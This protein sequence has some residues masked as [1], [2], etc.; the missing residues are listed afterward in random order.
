METSPSAQS[1]D[2]GQEIQV[3]LDQT[4]ATKAVTRTKRGSIL[5]K[6]GTK[7]DDKDRWAE[8][9][10]AVKARL[11]RQARS[12]DQKM[13]EQQAEHQRQIAALRSEFQGVNVNRGQTGDQLD[14]AHETTMAA[15]QK[16]LEE[17]LETGNAV[18]AAKIQRDMAS[19]EGK[20]WAAKTAKQTGGSSEN[21][22]RTE[23]AATTT[24]QPN[25]KANGPAPTKAGI[26]WAKA[27]TDWWDD[28]TDDV[29]VAA[30]SMANGLYAIAIRDGDD[31]ADP[32]LYE[33]IGTQVAKRFP[34]LGVK[35]KLNGRKGDDDDDDEGAST[36][37]GD[38][39]RGRAPV[40]PVDRTG[41][42]G[43][44]QANQ[45]RNVRTLDKTDQRTMRAMGLNPDDNKHV[46]EFL[47]QK[48]EY[49]AAQ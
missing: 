2:D 41:D 46:L 32:A 37:L 31:T 13:A 42:R 45:H 7:E 43:S 5:A 47:S 24:T 35:V 3:D 30:R 22:A 39:R 4:D 25:G 26:A 34:E 15:L 20:Y 10:K 44:R 17:A 12:F 29:S 23:A 48:T 14:A 19:A 8:N 6:A 21:G 49:E 1:D 38:D 40:V 16:D 28:T 27:N 18:K 33:R 11:A 9:S 36:E